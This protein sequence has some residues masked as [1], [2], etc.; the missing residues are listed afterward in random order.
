MNQPTHLE[1]YLEPGVVAPM[2]LPIRLWGQRSVKFEAPERDPILRRIVM[3]PTSCS[4]AELETWGCVRCKI[5]P[6]WIHVPFEFRGEASFHDANFDER[7]AF[8]LPRWPEEFK[9]RFPHFWRAPGTSAALA[10]LGLESGASDAEIRRA[11]RL[12][13]REVHP[14]R[15]GSQEAF[16]AL[17]RSLAD[18][19]KAVGI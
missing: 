18:A 1:C 15:G 11:F 3:R 7:R 14:D 13:A 5:G 6:F 16:V 12:K 9:R 4:R 2:C 17:Q 10:A 19:L 8:E